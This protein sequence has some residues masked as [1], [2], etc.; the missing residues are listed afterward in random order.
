VI[1]RLP[2]RMHFELTKEGVFLNGWTWRIYFWWPV[3]LYLIKRFLWC[4]G[5]CETIWHFE[6]GPLEFCWWEDDRY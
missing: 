3:D 6:I 5:P 4:F 2:A 1:L